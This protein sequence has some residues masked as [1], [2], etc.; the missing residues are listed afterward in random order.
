MVLVQALIKKKKNVSKIL[1]YT[2]GHK[3]VIILFCRNEM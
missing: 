2:Q 3:G 1:H